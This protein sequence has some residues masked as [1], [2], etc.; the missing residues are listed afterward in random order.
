MNKTKVDSTHDDSI[1]ATAHLGPCF[2]DKGN[3][4]DADIF[5]LITKRN[6][7]STEG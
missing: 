5:A 3:P 7:V 4:E 2:L 1:I 6:L